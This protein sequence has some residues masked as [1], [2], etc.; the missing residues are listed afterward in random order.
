VYLRLYRAPAK[1]VKWDDVRYNQEPVYFFGCHVREVGPVT[2]FQN[3]GD[4]A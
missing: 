1:D 3:A 2:T 4:K